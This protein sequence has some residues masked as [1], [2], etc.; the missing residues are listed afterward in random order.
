MLITFVGRK[1]GRTFT[2]PVRYSNHGGRIRCF[3]AS[4]NQWWRNLRGGADVSLRLRGRDLRYRANA[5]AD[6]PTRV[7]VGLEEFLTQ[8]PQDAP[9]YDLR[10]T[11]NGKPDAADLDRASRRTIMV[12]ATLI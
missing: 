3:T 11:A 9:Y 8:F 10:L 6:D 7:R 4:T 1:S 12:E 2:T 5:V